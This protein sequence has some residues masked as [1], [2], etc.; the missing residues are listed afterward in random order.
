MIDRGSIVSC[1]HWEKE[2]RPGIVLR[3]CLDG[4]LYIIAGTKVPPESGKPTDAIQVTANS[5]YGRLF[6]LSFDT[7]FK[8]QG[9]AFMSESKLSL[10]VPAMCPVDLLLRLDKLVGM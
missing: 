2:G 3:V 4:R 1:F 8:R 9:V 5:R 6:A 7:W 10:R